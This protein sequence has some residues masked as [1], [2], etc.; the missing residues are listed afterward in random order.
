MPLLLAN[1]LPAAAM[2]TPTNS[3]TPETVADAE[4][5]FGL[6]FTPAKREL[7]LDGLRN[8]LKAFGIF[9]QTD[10][11]SDVVPAILFN[12]IPLGMKLDTVHR[13]CKWS[14]PPKTP[15]P[16]SLDQA[17]FYSIGQLS[18]L[19]KSRKITSVQLTRMYLDRLKKYGP[20]LEC[21]VTL[22]EDLALEQ[23]RRADRE[24]AGG[25]YRGPLHGIPYGVKDLLATKGVRTTWGGAPYTN[26][27][28]DDDATVVKRL[29]AAGAVLVAKLSLGEL[30]MGDVW[31]G[32][33]TR[34]PWNTNQG[35]SGSSAG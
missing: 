29:N 21:V 11:A 17:A 23:A 8:Q 16:A 15:A 2:E 6:K 26:Q 20:Q 14:R 22:T 1:F 34:N 19:I 18:A 33:Q 35:S 10:L 13:K 12:P 27:M 7:M 31:Y 25:K 3:I 30:A 24:I 28:F 5:L 9:R 4:K 32:G